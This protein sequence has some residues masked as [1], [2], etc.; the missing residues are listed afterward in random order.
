MKYKLTIKKLSGHD[1]S[2]KVGKI[3]KRTGDAVKP[4]DTIFTIESGK[5][6]IKYLS[7]YDGMIE[8]LDIS[9]G[10][11]VSLNQ[12]IGEIEGKEKKSFFE[13]FK[14]MMK[15]SLK[16]RNFIAMLVSTLFMGL[17]TELIVATVPFFVQFNL[18]E[19]AYVETLIILPYLLGVLIFAPISLVLAKKYGDIKVFK[20]SVMFS[21][22]PSLIL[23][24]INLT[25]NLS[26]S[27]IIIFII[28]LF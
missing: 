9:E 17:F 25:P 10:D 7:E 14:S 24:F 1:K 18:G 5:G 11:I 15:F 22:V 12:E 4:G 3:N 13:D 16:Q 2:A 28:T 26:L 8:R 6:T 27:I 19:E 21:P 20:I 23:F